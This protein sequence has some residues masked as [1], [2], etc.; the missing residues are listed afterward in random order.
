MQQ[1]GHIGRGF[2]V[3]SAPRGEEP[4]F[5]ELLTWGLDKADKNDYTKNN[6]LLANKIRKMKTAYI[7]ENHDNYRHPVPFKRS[8]IR[9]PSE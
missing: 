8:D 6:A 1:D 5:A 7:S 9:K 4:S 3:G 2:G